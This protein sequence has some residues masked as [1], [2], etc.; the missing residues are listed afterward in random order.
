MQRKKVVI[1]GGGQARE[2]T[3]R[4]K[5]MVTVKDLAYHTCGFG[6]TD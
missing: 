6:A 3:A 4:V 1:D 5:G 2:R